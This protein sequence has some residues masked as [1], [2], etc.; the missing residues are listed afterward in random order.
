[1]FV[2]KIKSA[3]AVVLGVGVVLGGLGVGHGLFNTTEGVAQ[4]GTN[5]SEATTPVER[6]E[7]K[8]PEPQVFTGTIQKP[9]PDAAS[10]A[11]TV[12]GR[13][14]VLFIPSEARLDELKQRAPDLTPDKPLP[15]IDFAK[16]SVVLLYALDSSKNSLAL[17]NSDLTANPP[18]LGFSYRWWNGPARAAELPTIKFIY[19]IIPATPK[20]NV[21]LTS[22]PIIADRAVRTATEFSALLGSKDGGDTVDGLQ[23]VITPKAAAIKP[24]DDILIDVALHLADPGKAK[25]EKFGTT[26]TSVYVWDGKYSN[27]YR[28]HAFF[29]TTPDGKTMLLRPKEIDQWDKNAPH[30]VEVSAK[31]PYHLPNWV[32]GDTR[33]SLKTLGLDT[34]TPGTY[35]ITGL[36]EETGQEAD[37]RMGGKT[38]LWGG[39]ITSNT[40]TVE[41]KA[42]GADS[43]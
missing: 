13:H 33:K 14:G 20:V 11:A 34:T 22:L 9:G 1:M 3:S 2:S 38:Q 37:N 23:A 8:P 39:S 35:T 28:N 25:P 24:G 32:E 43:R 10:K 17:S 40:I 21:T 19:A 31:E 15:N 7:V 5:L 27:G 42:G 16:H 26:S 4:G 6:E 30:P 36:Y 18:D 12:I 29:V 41:V